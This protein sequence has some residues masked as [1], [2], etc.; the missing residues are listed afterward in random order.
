MSYVMFY[1]FIF[2]SFYVFFPF[3]LDA[4]AELN[5]VIGEGTNPAHS[6][7]SVTIS[8]KSGGVTAPLKAGHMMSCCI[9]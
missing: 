4:A 2:I 9:S 3:S 1:M 6:G 5:A 7:G 8:P